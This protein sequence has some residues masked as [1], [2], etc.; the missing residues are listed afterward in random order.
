MIKNFD[1]ET[2]P[3]TEFE[4]RTLL[5]PIL[6]G[7]RLRVGKDRAVTNKTIMKG[8]KQNLAL[9]ISEA[10]VRKLINHIRNN[11]LLEGLIATSDGYYI[12]TSEQELLDY[13]LSL[14]GREDAIRSVRQ[15]IE[16]QRRHLYRKEEKT[17]F[18]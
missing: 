13:E 11:D 9:N 4:L 3:L 18:D 12:A 6:A 7:L 5:P 2:Q 15:A 16:R 10:R 17:L 14:K 8:F 1:E